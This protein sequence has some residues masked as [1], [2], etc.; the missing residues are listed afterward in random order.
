MNKGDTTLITLREIAQ[1]EPWAIS[2]FAL[3][4]AKKVI[5]LFT[6]WADKNTVRK[7][8]PFDEE[9]RQRSEEDLWA[10]SLAIDSAWEALQAQGGRANFALAAYRHALAADE[11]YAPFIRQDYDRLLEACE[12]NRPARKPRKSRKAQ[13]PI[14]T[15]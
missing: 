13:S 4:C 3:R 2:M 11:G 10:A 6:Q 14:C 1:L 9:D 12:I 15:A 8:I 5:P 7:P